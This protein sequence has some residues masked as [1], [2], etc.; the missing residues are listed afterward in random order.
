M[1]GSKK[2][3]SVCI[4]GFGFYLWSCKQVCHKLYK[5]HLKGVV[6]TIIFCQKS[7]ILLRSIFAT[8]PL[9]YFC[10]IHS[11]AFHRETK[12]IHHTNFSSLIVTELALNRSFHHCNFCT[13]Q[14][15]VRNHRYLLSMRPYHFS[16]SSRIPGHKMMIFVPWVKIWVVFT[17]NGE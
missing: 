2:V 11:F 14:P 4:K 6:P 1:V 16:L 10:D 12:V 8:L 5:P 15:N 9:K 17:K 7:H 3:S 13:Y